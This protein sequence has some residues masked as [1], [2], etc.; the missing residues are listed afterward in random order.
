VTTTLRTVDPAALALDACRTLM[1]EHAD[2]PIKLDCGESRPEATPAADKR[3]AWYVLL[4]PTDT[5]IRVSIAGPRQGGRRP[6]VVGEP[7]VVLYPTGPRRVAVAAFAVNLAVV[8]LDT[9][10]DMAQM[11]R[12]A[13]RGTR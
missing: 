9:A 5:G 4:E 8:V 10:A 13:R 6:T 3:L 11:R 12:K 2:V 1:T 7:V